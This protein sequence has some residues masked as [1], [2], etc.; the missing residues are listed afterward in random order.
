MKNLTQKHWKELLILWY[1]LTTLAATLLVVVVHATSVEMYS[2]TAYIQG[3]VSV[4]AAFVFSTISVSRTYSDSKPA[5]SLLFLAGVIIS[6]VG[7]LITLTDP[8]GG[9]FVVIFAAGS[10]GLSLHV[11]AE[12]TKW[13]RHTEMIVSEMIVINVSVI[14][15]SV[16][17]LVFPTIMDKYATRTYALFVIAATTCFPVLNLSFDIAKALAP[18]PKNLGLGF[19]SAIIIGIL[20]VQLGRPI[21]EQ[22]TVVFGMMLGVAILPVFVTMLLIGKKLNLKF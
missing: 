1:L 6:V 4:L 3:L 8:N 10:I 19:L 9:W 7:L 21:G 22:S 16:C 5:N 15:A 20:V 2:P 18:S 13:K 14:M 12:Q 11:A 17:L